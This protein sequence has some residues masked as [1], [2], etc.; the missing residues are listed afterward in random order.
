MNAKEEEA[1]RRKMLQYV[2]ASRL[3]KEPE[4]D[5]FARMRAEAR[6]DAFGRWVGR[7]FWVGAGVAMLVWL[8]WWLSLGVTL[9]ALQTWL[10]RPGR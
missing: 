7:A 6:W 3:A 2:Q 8:P 10:E 9:F 5:P 1:W 4:H